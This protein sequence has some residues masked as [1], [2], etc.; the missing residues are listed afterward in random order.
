[1]AMPT[2]CQLVYQAAYRL[3]VKISVSTM[4]VQVGKGSREATKAG[5]AEAAGQQSHL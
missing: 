2:A 1:M 3:T 4:S 5:A